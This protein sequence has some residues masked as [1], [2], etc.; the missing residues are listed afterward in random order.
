MG[1][2]M[3]AVWPKPYWA[4]AKETVAARAACRLGTNAPCMRRVPCRRPVVR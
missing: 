4:M 2:N 1:A 3:G